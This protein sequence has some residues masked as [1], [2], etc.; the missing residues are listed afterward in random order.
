MCD[1]LY[2]GGAH[3]NSQDLLDTLPGGNHSSFSTNILRSA[4]DTTNRD[5]IQMSS[6]ATITHDADKACQEMSNVSIFSKLPNN[7]FKAD[8]TVGGGSL[9]R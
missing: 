9:R 3:I 6:L 4:K 2:L 7:L 5:I 1:D 8:N